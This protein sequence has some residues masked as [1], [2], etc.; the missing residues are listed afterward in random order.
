MDQIKP[1]EDANDQLAD[2]YFE[3]S[4]IAYKDRAKPCYEYL[5]SAEKNYL[6][7][8]K[9]DYKKICELLMVLAERCTFIEAY[10]ESNETLMKCVEY[11]SKLE[12]KDQNYALIYFKIARNQ[13]KK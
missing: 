11:T 4:K 2:I 7:K 12:E 13:Y 1:E 8:A 9:P 5:K 3:Y 10:G 6:S